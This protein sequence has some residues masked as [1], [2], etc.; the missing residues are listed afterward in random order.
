M[1]WGEQHAQATGGQLVR[2]DE[3]TQGQLKMAARLGLTI[4]GKRKGDLSDEISRALASGRLD[5]M[6]YVCTVTE[7]GY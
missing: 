7:R 6:P 4:E 2:K 1:T 3:P 5:M